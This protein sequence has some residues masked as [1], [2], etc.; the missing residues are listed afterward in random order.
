M[1]P[2]PTSPALSP[3]LLY[4]VLRTN[5]SLCKKSLQIFTKFDKWIRPRAAGAGLERGRGR[6]GAG[7]GGSGGGGPGSDGPAG[8]PSGVGVVRGATCAASAFRGD[9]EWSGVRPHH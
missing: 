2:L 6:G 7:W 5:C 9:G 4:S 3:L 1:R 8:G